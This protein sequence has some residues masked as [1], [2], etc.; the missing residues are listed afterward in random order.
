MAHGSHLVSFPA[1]WLAPPLGKAQGCG[2]PQLPPF[3][4]LLGCDS[5]ICPHVCLPLSASRGS[6]DRGQGL[7][8][9]DVC[10][11]SEGAAG[12]R[13]ALTAGPVLGGLPAAPRPRP[14]LLTLGL[15][16]GCG[17]RLRAW[18]A[19]PDAGD[20]CPPPAPRSGEEAAAGL[21]LLGGHPRGTQEAFG[22]LGYWEDSLWAQEGVPVVSGLPQ[23]PGGPRDPQECG[24][25]CLRAGLRPGVQL[26]PGGLGRGVAW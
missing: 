23:C 20:T 2:S 25:R 4:A 21:G 14:V 12:G 16:S 26:T 9:T 11:G 19:G 13:P 3:L 7:P 5:G 10:K 15:S 8:H 24:M 6:C 22:F 17:R 1:R 18:E